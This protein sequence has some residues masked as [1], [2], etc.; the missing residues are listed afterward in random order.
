MGEV[1]SFSVIAEIKLK[2]DM[3]TLTK[4]FIISLLI[5]S[6]SANSQIPNAGFETWKS[7]SLGLF[8]YQYAS[9]WE[10]NNIYFQMRKKQAPVTKTMDSHSGQYAISLKNVPD[11]GDFR[12]GGSINA[13]VGEPLD[14]NVS[15]KFPISSKP[16]SLLGFY[17]YGS[18]LTDTFTIYVSLYKDGDYIGG[19][20]RV[21]TTNVTTW[22]P[23]KVEIEYNQDE[24]PDSAS[25]SMTLGGY[26][27][28]VEGTE[29]ILDDLSFDT[30]I[31]GVAEQ[32]LAKMNVSVNPNPFTDFTQIQF[33][34]LAQGKTTIEVF[35]IIGNRI[36]LVTKD[37]LFTKGMQSINWNPQYNKPGVYFIKI[38]QPSASATIRVINN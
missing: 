20:D 10:N 30:D 31:T 35:D 19:G 11:T 5:S 22:S 3:K 24:T 14:D 4:L 28:V 17:K 38:T 9:G 23:F 25:I 18:A 37:E 6:L 8:S 33:E 2:T 13:I 15:Y 12:M 21:F 34:Q 32:Q 16:L 29:F 36:A 1:L 7:Q 27:S 26:S